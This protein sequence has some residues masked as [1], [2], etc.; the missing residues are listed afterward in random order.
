MPALS[1]INSLKINLRYRLN[2]VNWKTKNLKLENLG[3]EIPTNH[4]QLSLETL[5]KESFSKYTLKWL[6]NGNYLPL[7]VANKYKRVNFNSSS[8]MVDKVPKEYQNH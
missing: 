1:T 5:Q 8:L 2:V 3:L 4:L 7:A 6:C